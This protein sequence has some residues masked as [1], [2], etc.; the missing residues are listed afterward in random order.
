MQGYNGSQ[1]WDTAFAVH[2]IIESGSAAQHADSLERAN[3]FIAKNQVSADIDQHERYFRDRTAGAFPFSTVEQSWTVSDCTAKGITA[4][5]LLRDRV[6]QPLSPARIEAA[7]DVLLRDQNDDGGWSEYEKARAGTWVEAL[8]AAE[9]F[10][11]I[12]I[13]Y[14]YVETTSAC[15]QALAACR[16]TF[17]KR[18]VTEI[19]HAMRHGFQYLLR[20]Q[21][22]D[23]GWIGCWGVCFTYGTWFGVEG[24]FA[25]GAAATSTPVQRAMTFLLERQNA[26]G[27]WGES[28]RSCV[29]K[30]YVAHPDGSQVVHTAWALL[31]LSAIRE[32]T[33]DPELRY[34]LEIATKRAAAFLASRQLANGDWPNEGITGVFNKTCMIHYD[35]YRRVMPVW[36]LGRHLSIR[37]GE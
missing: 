4:A 16:R 6:R 5:L 33:T 19:D 21:R 17:P 10:G 27:G 25:A 8:N 13:A 32:R 29:E 22:A 15:L 30:T 20:A 7:V 1:F 11:N 14:S 2:A 12:M 3:D 36:A 26:D 31:G 34:T 28:Y 9:V 37:L 35:N 24:L 18:R 23:G